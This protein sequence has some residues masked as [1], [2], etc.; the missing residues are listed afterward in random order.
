MYFLGENYL[1]PHS[2]RYSIFARKLDVKCCDKSVGFIETYSTACSAC[3]PGLCMQ[4]YVASQKRYH[5]EG[6]K[7]VCQSHARSDVIVL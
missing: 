5:K 1:Q 4:C 2:Y 7:Q 3:A 6:H